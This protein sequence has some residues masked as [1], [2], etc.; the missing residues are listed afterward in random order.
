[1]GKGELG[2]ALM[3]SGR[4]E[5]ANNSQTLLKTQQ[6]RTSASGAGEGA[7]PT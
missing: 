5:A 6:S 4:S 2:F 1:M 3:D 7:C